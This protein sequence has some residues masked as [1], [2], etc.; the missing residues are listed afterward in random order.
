MLFIGDLRQIF[1]MLYVGSRPSI[2]G[3]LL[4]TSQPSSL[5]GC[6][7]CR[8]SIRL[9]ALREDAAAERATSKFL[10]VLLDMSSDKF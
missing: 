3:P 8:E 4:T 7:D 5:F 9:F 6:M 2:I 1:P 10:F